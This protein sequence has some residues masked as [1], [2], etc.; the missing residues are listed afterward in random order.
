MLSRWSCSVERGIL[1][2]S[3]AFEV[4]TS[5]ALVRQNSSQYGGGQKEISVRIK[6]IMQLKTLWA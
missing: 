3:S 4:Y 2:T 6:Q 5:H 1:S